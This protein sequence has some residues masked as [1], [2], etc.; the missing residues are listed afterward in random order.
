MIRHNHAVVA[1]FLVDTH[2]LIHVHIAFVGKCFPKVEKATL[3]IPEVD[4]EDFTPGAE[5][6]NNIEYLPARIHKHFGDRTLTKIEAVIFAGHNRNELLQ[7]FYAAQHALDA[8]ESFAFRH[9]RVV[10][11]ASHP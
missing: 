8:A 10:W 6:A 1:N 9:S 3:D 7:S 2:R 5:I 4:I 11:M